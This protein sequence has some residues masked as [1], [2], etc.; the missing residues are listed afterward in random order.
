MV[1]PSA[2]AP[3]ETG[4][5]TVPMTRPAGAFSMRP[6]QAESAPRNTRSA[7]L[8]SPSA[9]GIRAGASTDDDGDFASRA[10]SSTPE[11]S[12]A[13]RNPAPVVM[14]EMVGVA[15]SNARLAS[16]TSAGVSGCSKT[17]RRSAISG[18]MPACR[19][20]A[21]AVASLMAWARR[22]SG[23]L[24]AAG[25]APV[26]A[27]NFGL[28][29]SA[30]CSV[31]CVAAWPAC[32]TLPLAFWTGT[33]AWPARLPNCAVVLARA[34]R[35]NAVRTALESGGVPAAGVGRI[36]LTGVVGSIATTTT[37]RRQLIG[38]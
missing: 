8:R 22:A 7:A 10:S 16:R 17:A 38:A 9:T 32:S 2:S 4:S 13:R 25:A 11:R 26:G 19:G 27:L 35:A 31:S 15:A 18:A 12:T 36:G 20:T 34:W 1:A 21:S 29:A 6:S 3:L 24:R 28:G 14:S 37:P 33:A 30:A 5:C 23:A